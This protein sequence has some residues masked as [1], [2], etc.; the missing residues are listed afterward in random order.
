[1][2]GFISKLITLFIGANDLCRSCFLQDSADEFEGN[3]RIAF[4]RMFSIPKVVVRVILLF[5]ISKI[6]QLTEKSTYCRVMK[7]LGTLF[8]CQCAF[9]DSKSRS[10]M[11]LQ[12]IEYNQRFSIIVKE[13]RSLGMMVSVDR[14][15]EDV[16]L[17]EWSL[18]FISK[19]DCFHPNGVVHGILSRLV[20]NNLFL[21]ESERTKFE[22]GVI[23]EYRVVGKDDG[24]IVEW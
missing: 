13:F 6:Y 22:S 19:V 24:I 1:M 23:P 18:D 20:W 7:R 17:E 4:N 16:D 12:T 2:W 5:K 11:D 8:E 3:L 21:K 14:V 9:M 10:L 15:L